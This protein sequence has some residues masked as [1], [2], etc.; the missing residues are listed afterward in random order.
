MRKLVLA[1]GSPRREEILR[2]LGLEVEVI[3]SNISEETFE[4]LTPENTVVR[5][6]LEKARDVAGRLD[7]PGLVIGADTI[8]VLDGLI[9]GKPENP[10][11]AFDMLN[12]LSG[13][14]HTVITGL[15]LVDRSMGVEMADYQCTRVKMKQIESSRLR[16]YIQTGEPFDKAGA[17]A[18][19]GKASVFV[20]SIAGCFFNVM[21]L[22]VAMLDNMLRT[23]GID[24][25][26]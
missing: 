21:G 26:E 22:P 23:A 16:K 2:R 20:D 7:F 17:Y 25:F 24:L 10:E 8:V 14:E 3:P 15:A 18:V 1:S 12:R 6:A 19:Q 5:L 13:R 9:M 4:G 11:Q